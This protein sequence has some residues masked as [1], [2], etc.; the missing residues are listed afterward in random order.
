MKNN[1]YLV[2]DLGT[3]SIKVLAFNGQGTLLCRV[4]MP[5]KTMHPKPGW[6][7]QDPDHWWEM[8]VRGIKECVAA[9]GH[10]NFAAISFSGQMSAPVFLDKNGQVL[11]PS[12]LVADV[13]NGE[14]SKRLNESLGY[15]FA[16]LTG[17]RP[18]EAFIVSKLLWFKENHP[19]L[20][21]RLY[22]FLLPKDYIRFRLTGRL[23]TDPT[24]ASNTLVYRYN[25]LK[26]DE[27]MISD[28]GLRPD[29]FPKLEQSASIC[30]GV[31][32]E[33]FS[34]I[35]I[36]EGTPVAVGAA[37]MACSQIG[38]GAVED[39]CL[40]ITLSTSVQLVSA[41]KSAEGNAA[42]TYHQ[43]ADGG[44]YQMASIFSGGAGT[45]F[46]YRLIYGKETLSS[47]DYLSMERE[48][49]LSCPSSLIFLP[50]LTGSGSPYFK[51]SDRAAWFGL[52][53]ATTRS[54][55]MQAAF[56]GIGYNIRENA[57]IMS[58]K[59]IVLGGGG[60]RMKCWPPLLANILGRDVSM[61]ENPDAS[62]L[63]ALIIGIAALN[64]GRFSDSLVRVSK[65]VKSNPELAAQY[66]V[67]Y[68][69]YLEL[70][71]AF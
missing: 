5:N 21:E 44:L 9:L 27:N 55:M 15:K 13:R 70:Y 33:A 6:V 69:R 45:D 28:C 56:E 3:T 17:N 59:K 31:T 50:F 63:G 64:G 53:M 20:Y 35:N 12:I 60:S 29:I 4:A 54:E 7:Q 37:D 57:K 16:A 8:T 51:S 18:I 66:D 58:F 38:S 36:P 48:I 24:D 49:N 2:V 32:S 30:G 25:S 46:V 34:I 68:K 40:A 23:C 26:W 22:V 71:A 61:L 10:N 11:Y 19:E 39:G 1:D 67:L 43:R 41:V 14:Q 52:S 42:L 65:I 47:E 62:G